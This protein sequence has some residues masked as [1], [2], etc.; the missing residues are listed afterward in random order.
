[1]GWSQT[2]TRYAVTAELPHDPRH[3][4]LTLL[5]GTVEADGPNEAARKAVEASAHDPD[6]F[7]DGEVLVFEVSDDPATTI[8]TGDL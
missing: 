5:S 8:P 6:T 7:V 1:M 2:M 4:D 3:H